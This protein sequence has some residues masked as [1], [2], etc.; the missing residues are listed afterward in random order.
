MISQQM[1]EE[2]DF[3]IGHFRKFDG[4]VT[5]TL[6]DRETH[7]VANVLS[8]STNIKYWLVTTS[9]LIVDVRT[10][11]RTDGRTSFH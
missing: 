10:Y 6:D 8:T 3:E 11:E 7:I 1:A 5:L 9:S 4:P 2:I